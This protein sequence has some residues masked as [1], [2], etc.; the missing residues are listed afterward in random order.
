MW[1]A[2]VLIKKRTEERTNTKKNT[3]VQIIK[4]KP[5]KAV[6]TEISNG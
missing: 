6:T 2:V 5:A 1:K 4:Q 3:I